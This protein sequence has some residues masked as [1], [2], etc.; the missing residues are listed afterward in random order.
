MNSLLGKLKAFW[1]I[2]WFSKDTYHKFEESS[3]NKSIQFLK[4]DFHEESLDKKNC[5]FKD[6]SE[7]A[8]NK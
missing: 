1:K 3:L 5:E 6:K 8:G 4:I 7:A 2:K